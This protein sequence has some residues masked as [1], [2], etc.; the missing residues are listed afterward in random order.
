M[1]GY[2]AK[3]F[4]LSLGVPPSWSYVIAVVAFL[5]IALAVSQL[6]KPKAN[7]CVS[8]GFARA[9]RLFDCAG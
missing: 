4:A 1:P 7:V 8:L 2:L 9:S 3:L 5:L 6:L